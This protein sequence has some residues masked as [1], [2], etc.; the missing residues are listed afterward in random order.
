VSATTTDA[1]LQAEEALR[2]AS[3][4]NQ[5]IVSRLALARNEQSCSGLRVT[6]ATLSRVLVAADEMV[7]SCEAMLAMGLAEHAA[8][9]ADIARQMSMVD[10]SPSASK[11]RHRFRVVG[12]TP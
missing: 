5:V 9:A 10:S 1:L 2:A 8:A 3:A 7:D 4:Y 12:P 11:R 6:S